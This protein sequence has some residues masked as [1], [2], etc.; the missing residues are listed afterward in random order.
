ML[1]FLLSLPLAVSTLAVGYEV[2]DRQPATQT[3]RRL[4]VR[5]AIMLIMYLVF[6]PAALYGLG[7]AFASI[8]ALHLIAFW[9]L[10]LAVKVSGSQ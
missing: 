6:G 2:L 10:R 8:V 3:L 1:A 5:I 4:T 9:G 7:G